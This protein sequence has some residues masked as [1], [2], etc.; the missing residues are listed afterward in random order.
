MHKFRVSYTIRFFGQMS[1]RVAEK[2]ASEMIESEKLLKKIQKKVCFRR[3][4]LHSANAQI[5]STLNVG[6]RR[7]EAELRFVIRFSNRCMQS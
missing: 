2:K 6:G 3:F 5:S 1:E 4:R 7:G